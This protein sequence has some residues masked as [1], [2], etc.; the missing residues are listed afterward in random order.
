MRPGSTAFRYVC[1]KRS[2][3]G[4]AAS[5]RMG[6]RTPRAS[7]SS[8][9]AVNRPSCHSAYAASSPPDALAQVR[10]AEGVGAVGEERRAHLGGAVAVRVGLHHRVDL[11]PGADH[12][13]RRAHVTGGGGEIDLEDGRP[14]GHGAP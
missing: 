1:G 6:T 3:N 7:S 10:H 12:A 13:A 8:I 14:G 2:T 5:S 11:P 4:E 9:T